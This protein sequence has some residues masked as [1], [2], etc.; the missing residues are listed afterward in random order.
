MLARGR[1]NQGVVQN[2]AMPISGLRCSTFVIGIASHSTGFGVTAETKA[3][4]AAINSRV[5][6]HGQANWQSTR[7]MRNL[8]A[9]AERNG[10]FP[11]FHRLPMRRLGRKLRELDANP[12]QIRDVR[13]NRFRRANA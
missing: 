8:R 4:N 1:E 5:P 2:A 10:L 7:P 12:V 3:T 6:P 13:Q 11:A 9:R